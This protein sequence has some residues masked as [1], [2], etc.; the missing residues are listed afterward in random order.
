VLI[1]FFLSLSQQIGFALSSPGKKMRVVRFYAVAMSLNRTGGASPV[2]MGKTHE[3][4][5][6][7]WLSPDREA[8][9]VEDQRDTAQE[10]GLR[11]FDEYAASKLFAQGVSEYPNV[12]SEFLSKSGDLAIAMPPRSNQTTSELVARKANRLVVIKGKRPFT[13]SVPARVDRDETD[14]GDSFARNTMV[15]V[16]IVLS[17]R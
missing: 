15:A 2:A 7:L 10:D 8:V 13:F 3:T 16:V 5:V 14:Q 6:V 4:V 12:H 11:I 1:E 17:S 9:E